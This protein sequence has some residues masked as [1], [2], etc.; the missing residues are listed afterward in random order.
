LTNP[1]KRT[2]DKLLPF[3]AGKNIRETGLI[4]DNLQLKKGSDRKYVLL[5][6]SSDNGLSPSNLQN[7]LDLQKQL[8]E[9]GLSSVVRLELYS[10]FRPDNAKRV[11]PYKAISEEQLKNLKG[12]EI[13]AVLVGEDGWNP[14]ENGNKLITV[15][16]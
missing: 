8:K 4:T 3:E 5:H 15:K 6:L 9:E 2:Y 7:A 16:R 13:N 12:Y 10:R 14:V 1:V 11:K